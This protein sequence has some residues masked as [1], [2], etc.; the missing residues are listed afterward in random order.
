VSSE[1]AAGIQEIARAAEEL[2]RL[3]EKLSL[4]IFRFKIDEENA[5]VFNFRSKR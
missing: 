1:S 4:M 3:T 5:K 2:K